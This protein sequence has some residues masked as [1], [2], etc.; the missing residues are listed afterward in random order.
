MPIL[1]GNDKP[2]NRLNFVGH[3]DYGVPLR[4][5]QGSAGEEVVLNISDNEGFHVPSSILPATSRCSSWNIICAIVIGSGIL[6]LFSGSGTNG[7]WLKLSA[8]PA[9]T[10]LPP[11]IFRS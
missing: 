2:E 1:R 10:V 8:K 11:L 6:N 4:N 7:I 3:R 9:L 5:C